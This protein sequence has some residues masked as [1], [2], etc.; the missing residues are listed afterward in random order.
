MKGLKT[1]K[2][3]EKYVK[4]VKILVKKIILIKIFSWKIY[5]QKNH[6]QII[7]PHEK[8]VQTLKRGKKLSL[9]IVQNNGA[10]KVWHFSILES[11]ILTNKNVT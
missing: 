8:N 7:K 6:F 1:V 2:N 11:H 3:C 9:K 4:I 5:L 10:M